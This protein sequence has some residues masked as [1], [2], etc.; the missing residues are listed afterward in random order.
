MKASFARWT[1]LLLGASLAQAAE[2][3]G[4]SNGSENKNKRPNILFILTDDQDSHMSSVD[5]MPHVKADII[6][7]GVTYERHFCTVA[8]CCP[9]RATLWTGKAAHNHN[10]TDVKPPHGGYPKVVASGVNDDYLPLWLQAAGYNTYYAGKLWN[11]HSVSN[12]DRPAAARGFN[13]SAFLLDPYTYRYWDSRVSHDGGPP[14]SYAGRYSTDVVAESSYA[15]LERALEREGEPWFLT[16]APTAPH[17]NWVLDERTGATYLVAPQVAY[18]HEHLFHDYE[19]PRG[20]S[21]NAPIRGAA[22]WPGGLAALNESVLAYN[23]F[24]Q[25]QRL[26]A[27]QPVD[28]MLHELVGMLAAAGQLDDTYIFYSTDNGYHVSQHAMHPGKECGLDTDVHIPLFARGPGLPEGGLVDVVT[29]HTD[30]APTFLRIAG[31]EGRLADLDGE[32]IPLGE[33]EEVNG[34]SEH[35]AVEYW[36]YGVPE[37]HYGFR[38]DSRFEAGVMQNIYVNNTYRGLRVVAEGYSLYYS[39]WC[40]GE[41]ELYDMVHD[42]EQTVNVLAGLGGGGGGGDKAEGQVEVDPV[43]AAARVRLQVA[44]RGHEAVVTR[45]EALI[46]VLRDCKGEVCRRPWKTL[47]PDGGIGSLAGALESRFDGFYER[48]PRMAFDGCPVAYFEDKESS[49]HVQPYY[50][51]GGDDVLVGQELEKQVEFDHQFGDEWVLAI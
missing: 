18:R 45:L 25:R 10:V 32:P 24:Y 34:R 21:F 29:T 43:V 7:K 4:S 20:A 39:V 2:K 19:V 9:S 26:R 35:V 1:A 6:N 40:T 31:V 50:N 37:G 12:Y 33:G 30:L 16:V 22:G 3:T 41:R 11:F 36:G 47:H 17:S 48:Q 46:M 42:P 15:L 13:G 28:E 8:L 5:H 44:G 38:S 14:V 49:A 27:L 51:G 23:D